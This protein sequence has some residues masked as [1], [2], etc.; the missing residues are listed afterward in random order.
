VQNTTLFEDGSSERQFPLNHMD[1]GT[2][3]ILVDD[4]FSFRAIIDCEF[5]QTAPWQVNHYPMPFPLVGSD[6]ETQ[7]HPSGS[8]S[9]CASERVAVRVCSKVIHQEV[10]RRR[11]RTTENRAIPRKLI[12]EDLD[13]PASRMYASFASQNLAACQWQMQASSTRWCGSPLI[14]MLKG[15]NGTSVL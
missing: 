5:A 2:Q 1:L 11:S 14:W 12:A 3:N 6:T 9:P 15:Q 10:S 8:Q 4:R 7:R 13:S